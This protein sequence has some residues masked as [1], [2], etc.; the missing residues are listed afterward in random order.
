MPRIA[1]S[2]LSKVTALLIAVVPLL[3]FSSTNAADLSSR[4]VAVSDTKPSATNVSNVFNFTIPSVTPLGSIEFE[5]CSNS[6]FVGQPCT[7]PAGFSASSVALSAQSGE[8]G[9]TIDGSSGVNRIVITRSSVNAVA[10]PVSYTFT[11]LLN[12]ATA[13]QSVYIRISTFA[14]SDASGS[15]TDSGAVVFS[16]ASGVTVSGY[17]PPYLIFCAGVTVALDCTSSGGNLLNFGDLRSTQTKALSSEFSGSTNDPGGFSTTITGN[18][19][20]SGNNVIPAMNPA[21][22]SVKGQSQF[23]MNLRANN[24]PAIGAEVTGPGSSVANVSLSNV[25]LFYYN[26]QVITN[27][28]FPTEFNKFT[29]SYIVNVSSSQLPGIYS[30]T[31][32]YIAVAAF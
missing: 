29:A 6:P 22:A 30:T 21:G 17:V 20:T 5:Y 9:F 1:S 7:A 8:T 31:L 13:N 19:M 2:Q 16:T 26:S 10:V 3:L 28:P 11:N 18:T 4:S 12:P 27:S 14:S 24:N 25:N 23:G 15:Y 32:T